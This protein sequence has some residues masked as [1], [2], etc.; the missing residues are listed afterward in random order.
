[1]P[2]Q[3]ELEDNENQ[4]PSQP[5][6]DDAELSEQELDNASGGGG[7]PHMTPPTVVSNTAMGWDV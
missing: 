5:I 4:T 1:M 7:Q 2:D 6:P 3:M